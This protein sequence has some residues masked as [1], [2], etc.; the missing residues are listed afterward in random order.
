MRSN[1][2]TPPTEKAEPSRSGLLQKV[3]FGV[4]EEGQL[5]TTIRTPGKPR[6]AYACCCTQPR[7]DVV[8]VTAES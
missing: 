7:I 5:R 8:K 4:L 2:S 6:P 3:T 1:R